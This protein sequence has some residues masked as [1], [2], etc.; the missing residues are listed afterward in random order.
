MRWCGGGMWRAV[1][2]KTYEK[3]F[4]R[5]NQA[6][7][8]VYPATPLHLLLFGWHFECAATARVYQ[9]VCRFLRQEGPSRQSGG[10][11]PHYCRGKKKTVACIVVCGPPRPQ[12]STEAGSRVR[13]N[14]GMRMLKRRAYYT[15]RGNASRSLRTAECVQTD[16]NDFTFPVFLPHAADSFPQNARCVLP[17]ADTPEHTCLP[18]SSFLC[19]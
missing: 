4:W 14:L 5:A 16:D 19:A 7:T 13:W 12:P 8:G 17:A 15:W 3:S 10:H 2:H 6:Y 1:C 9:Q 11:P 18:N